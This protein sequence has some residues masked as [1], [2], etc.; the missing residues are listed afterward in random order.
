MARHMTIA[1]EHRGRGT[2]A[3]TDAPYCL[4]SD[5]EWGYEMRPSEREDEW[6]ATHR[7]DLD[8]ALALAKREAPLMV[9][10]GWTVPQ[11]LADIAA[12]A[13]ADTGE[14]TDVAREGL[15]STEAGAG[16]A[17]S[18]ASD[19]ST[20]PLADEPGTGKTTGETSDAR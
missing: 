11:I 7:F 1:V 17:L 2:W 14:T 18:S 20:G 3:V 5:G 13:G 10:N 8:D 16:I 4:G 9:V 19:E 15:T 6:L 12:R